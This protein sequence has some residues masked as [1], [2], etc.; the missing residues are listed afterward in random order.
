MNFGLL[1]L[2]SGNLQGITGGLRVMISHGFVSSALFLAI[3][4]LYDRHHNRLL[5][6]YSGLATVMPLF[7]AAFF[8]LSIA[9][10][11]LPGTS[12]F[13]GELLI[14]IGLFQQNSTAAFFG[15]ASLILGAGYSIWLF[16]RA[17]F[18]NVK[19]QYLSTFYDLTFRESVIL[20]TFLCLIL[21]MGIYPTPVIETRSSS[22]LALALTA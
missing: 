2:R 12:S 5:R 1:G 10:M 19:T 3:G 11:S 9:N 14:G 6:Y 8:L 21:R 15:L 16:N 4:V 20:G 18:G 22:A 17:C 13:V 7:S